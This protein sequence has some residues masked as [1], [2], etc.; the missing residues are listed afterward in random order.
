MIRRC[1]SIAA[2]GSRGAQARSQVVGRCRLLLS[3]ANTQRFR[4]GVLHP[5]CKCNGMRLQRT[6]ASAPTVR[7]ALFLPVSPA[8]TAYDI[9]RFLERKLLQVLGNHKRPVLYVTVMAEVA[10]V[11]VDDHEAVRVLTELRS[12]LVDELD[13]FEGDGEEEAP[14]PAPVKPQRLTMK[15]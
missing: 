3:A 1:F 11:A 10:A 15:V 9:W 2:A 14:E 6:N 8:Q 5:G 4:G 7:A 12:S 13:A